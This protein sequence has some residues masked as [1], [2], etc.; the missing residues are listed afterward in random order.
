[1]HNTTDDLFNDARDGNTDNTQ[2]TSCV[3]RNSFI[4]NTGSGH[5][6]YVKNYVGSN[7]TYVF[8][9]ITY[10]NVGEQFNWIRHYDGDTNSQSFIYDHLTGYRLSTD[11]G[12]NKE[13]FGN[14]D[15][16]GEATL[17]I[18]R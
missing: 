7:D 17:S 12:D 15:G 14:S 10:W 1:M 9:N 16:D 13:L 5:G 18:L 4:Y 6:F 2:L 8:E 11:E 3:V